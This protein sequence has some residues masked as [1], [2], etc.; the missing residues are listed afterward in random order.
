MSPFSNKDFR[1]HFWDVI[2]DGFFSGILFWVF[3]FLQSE[4]PEWHIDVSEEV[5]SKIRGEE[6]HIPSSVLDIIFDCL[7]I[8]A[9]LGYVFLDDA[10]YCLP[11]ESFD[12]TESH[13]PS[14]DD[15][16]S[17]HEV[18]E[19]RSLEDEFRIFLERCFEF[20]KVLVCDL[21][22]IFIP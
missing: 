22:W 16:F 12:C 11:T 8:H 13:I 9:I 4:L 20:F 19:E 2:F 6:I 18:D 7:F 15:M 10:G 1:S 5:L 17:V 3:D 21:P 14:V